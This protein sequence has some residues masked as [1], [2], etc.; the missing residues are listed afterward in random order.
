VKSQ[1]DSIQ[2][3]LEGG[4]RITALDALRRFGTMRLAAR[5]SDLR[6]KGIPITMRWV[7][8]GEARVAEY[9]IAP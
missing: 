3:A 4:A 9:R 8:K 6:R 7:K 2:K 1:A 5:I